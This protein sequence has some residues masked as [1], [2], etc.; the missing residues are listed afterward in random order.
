LGHFSLS[1]ECSL[2][3]TAHQYAFALPK[4]GAGRSGMDPERVC[5]RAIGPI[6]S[7]QS[8]AG[9]KNHASG[10]SAVQGYPDPGTQPR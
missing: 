10:F 2:E 5:L 3:K 1:G 7:R 6:D 9:L 4:F 8:F